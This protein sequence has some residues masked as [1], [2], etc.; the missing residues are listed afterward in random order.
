MILESIFTGA[1]FIM[2][3]P[4]G[5]FADYFGRKENLNHWLCILSDRDFGLWIGTKFLGLSSGRNN[6][7]CGIGVP[8]GTYE[9]MIY[10]T[11]KQEKREDPIQGG[12]WK[13]RKC[14]DD[15]ARSSSTNR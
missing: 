3:I 11:L 9:A 14:P 13:I 5:T 4:S 7:G 12:F 8:I 10:E 6:L 2:E 1:I 15:R